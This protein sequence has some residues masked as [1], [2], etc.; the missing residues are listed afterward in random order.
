MRPNVRVFQLVQWLMPVIPALWE[1][2]AE[3]SLEE[4]SSRPAWATWKDPVSKKLQKLARHSGMHLWFQ[5]LRRLRQEDHLSLRRLRLQCTMMVTLHSSL[6]NRVRLSQEKKK[7]FS[8]K[9]VQ[10][11]P[12]LK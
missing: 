1:A 5:L 10:S 3:G 6:G 7:Q 8:H 9:L 4:G 11:V 12:P 2:K